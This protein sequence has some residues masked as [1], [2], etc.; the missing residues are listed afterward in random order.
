MQARTNARMVFTGSLAMFSN[1]FF[2]LPEAGNQVFC[3]EISK[4]S[5][6][7]FVQV[8]A[9][10]YGDTSCPGHMKIREVDIRIPATLT[11]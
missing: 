4:V 3:S 6:R 5:V 2:S 9:G 1:R 7:V 10:R 11:T 8:L